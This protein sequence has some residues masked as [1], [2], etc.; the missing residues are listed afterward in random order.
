M[1]S[2]EEFKKDLLLK[3]IINVAQKAINRNKKLKALK[4]EMTIID[5]HVRIVSKT[6]MPIDF[7]TLL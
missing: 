7:T 6:G 3:Y 2:Q 5:A 4:L 1:C